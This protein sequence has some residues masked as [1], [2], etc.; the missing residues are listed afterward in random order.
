MKL[1]FHKSEVLVLGATGEEQA[2]VANLLNCRQGTLPFNYLG[3]PMSGRRITMAEMEPL[4]NLVALK[5]EPWQGRFMSSAARLVLINACLSNLPMYA[6][7]LF[8]LSDEDD[9]KLLWLQLLKA[10][11]P[12]DRFFSTSPVGGSPFW[13]SLHKL[14][15]VFKQGARFFPGNNS[16]ILFWT[17]HWTGE[18]ALS[19]R[20]P[21]LFQICADPEITVERA[22][23]GDG[24]RIF[25]RRSFG[26]EESNLWL[27]MVQ[28]LEEV[29]PGEGRD[30]V[31][32][33][34]EASGRFSRPPTLE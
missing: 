29:V 11:Y 15:A 23:E 12:V 18:E 20:Y 2:R 14:K 31:L 3:F 22:Y 32:W 1:N 21:R 5:M 8:L 17:D 13:H 24:W 9:S 34:L 10:K 25:F 4:V 16:D 33:K 27:Q 6:M 30:K 28:D 19:V 7:G 26:Q